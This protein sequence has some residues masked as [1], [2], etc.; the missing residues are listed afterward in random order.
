[1]I[2]N[3]GTRIQQLRTARNLSQ[4][5]LA[6]MLEVTSASVSAYELGERTP[7]LKVLMKLA[8]LFHVSTD[9]LLG[10]PSSEKVNLDGLKP[11]DTAAILTLINSLK[12][13]A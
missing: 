13:K 8:N 9:Y 11:E 1:M 2:H 10:M 12:N 7:S 4:P 6:K 3:L 5:Q